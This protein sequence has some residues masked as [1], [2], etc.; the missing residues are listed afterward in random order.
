MM[1]LLKSVVLMVV[2][3]EGLRILLLPSYQAKALGA[4]MVL[5]GYAALRGGVIGRRRQRIAFLPLVGLLV[6]GGDVFYNLVIQQSTQFLGLDWMTILFGVIL[7]FYNS[8]PARYDAE[9]LFITIF[10]GLF[11]ITL[12][13]PLALLSL[14]FGGKAASFYTEVFIAKPI[15]AMLNAVG[16]P[17]TSVSNWVYYTGKYESIQMGMGISCSGVYSLAI[18]F[19]AFV[20]YVHVRYKAFNARMAALLVLG[21]VGTFL[22]NL[23]RVFAIAVIGFLYGKNALIAAHQNFGWLVFMLWVCVFWYVGFVVVLGEKRL[24]IVFKADERDTESS[25]NKEG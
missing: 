7:V 12:S 15:A 19:S 6:I 16:I 23:L 11:F 2:L 13:L 25:G 18:F 20:A 4:V 8:I 10:L 17:A 9:A 21:L 22:A 24:R 14:E 5:V 1:R 3:F